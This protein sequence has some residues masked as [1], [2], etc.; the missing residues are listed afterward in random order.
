MISSPV[1]PCR[2]AARV[3]PRMQRTL[4]QVIYD[5]ADQDYAIIGDCRSAALVS[6][7]GSI[8]W[9]CWPRFDS[10]SLFGALLDAQAGHWRIAPT[11]PFTTERR[12]V[13]ET[14]VLETRFQTET[15]TILL[16]D[17]MPVTSEQD[18]RK[19]LLPEHEILRLIE[20]EKGEIEV[21]I[22]FDSRPQDAKRSA[23]VHDAGTRVSRAQLWLSDSDLSDHCP[24]LLWRCFRRFLHL[25]HQRFTSP[26]ENSSIVQVVIVSLS[27]LSFC[28]VCH[29]RI[30][31]CQRL[32]LPPAGKIC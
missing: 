13:D 9:L 15:G 6:R 8:D 28:S 11:A 17:L 31:F 16:T 10:A 25:K 30:S 14:N 20:C 3:W 23:R 26:N 32:S 2:T 22:V 7:K 4:C 24:H 5:V 29:V 18:K 12:Y 27:R 19:L 21:E 1:A